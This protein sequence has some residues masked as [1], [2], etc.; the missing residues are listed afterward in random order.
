MADGIAR[1]SERANSRQWTTLILLALASIIAYV[2]RGNLTFAIIDGDFK[3]FFHIDNIDRGLVSSAFFWSYAALQIPAGWVAD[4]YG[5]KYPVIAGFAVWSILTA[6]TAL[7]TGFAS[8]FAVRLLLGVGEAIIQ[9]AAL[10]WVRFNF[11]EKQRGLAVGLFMSGS[12]FGPAL[13]APLSVWLIESYGWRMMFLILGLAA[14]LWLVPFLFLARDDRATGV[15]ANAASLPKAQMSPMQMA[16]NPIIWGVVIGT[17]C[18]MYFVYFCLTWMPVYFS[19]ARGL[20]LGSSGLFTAFSFAGI[21]IM[22]I[23]GGLAADWLIARGGDA[24]KVRKVFIIA[25]FVI[26]ATEVVGGNS[27]SLNV[28]LFFSVFSL[29]GLGLATANYWALTLTLL[30]GG[31]IGRIVGIQNCAASIA[32]IVAPIVTGWLVQKTGAY[33]APMQTVMAVLVMGIAAYIFLVR[34]KYAPKAA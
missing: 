6:V 10:R 15:V 30:P 2:D 12:K 19:E 26:A 20:S 22:A 23:I 13:G 25:G 9:P 18:Y 33:T 1:I 34:E 7:T 8:L 16:A 27:T 5:S 14:L 29:S 3:R 21:A 17:F 24:V 4:R 28:A 32:G 31:A 11:M